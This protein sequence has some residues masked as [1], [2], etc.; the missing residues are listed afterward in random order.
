MKTV[1]HK[2]TKVNRDV[3]VIKPENQQTHSLDRQTHRLLCEHI[4]NVKSISNF[5]I[6]KLH[7]VIFR[8]GTLKLISKILNIDKF[9]QL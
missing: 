1:T 2:T 6:Y 8:I 3:A 7:R 4:K 9:L 5:V